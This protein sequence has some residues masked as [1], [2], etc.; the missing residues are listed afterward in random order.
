MNRPE[1]AQNNRWISSQLTGTPR[2]WLIAYMTLIAGV[3]LGFSAWVL[4]GY[5]LPDPY[6]TAVFAILG[7]IKASISL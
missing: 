1:A 7:I 3:G 6:T 4:I 5:D 2:K